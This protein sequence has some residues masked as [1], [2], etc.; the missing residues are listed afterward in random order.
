MCLSIAIARPNDILASGKHAG[1]EWMIVHNQSGYRCGY[2][3]VEAG[4]PWH[5]MDYNDVDASVHGGLTFAAADVPCEKGGKDTGFWFGFDCAHSGDAKDPSIMSQEYRDHHFEF[6]RSFRELHPEF[7]DLIPKDTVKTTE[8]VQ[9]E[10]RSLCE[11]AAS[12]SSAKITGE[13]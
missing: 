10:C 3:K 12:A 11:Q 13:N 9:A 4:H 8:Y 5:G 6:E 7:D 2:V 1:H